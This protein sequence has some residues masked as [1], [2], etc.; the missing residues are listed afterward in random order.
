M[1][2]EQTKFAKTYKNIIRYKQI[3][4]VLI[5]H[6]FYDFVE[7]SKLLQHLHPKDKQGIPTP[8]EA[9]TT[10]GTKTH[11][12]RVR[13]VLE[14]LGPTFIKLGQFASNRPDLIP[15]KL[16]V[17]LHKLLDHVPPFS[18]EEAA[19]LI[20]TEL[21][22]EIENV[23]DQ[24]AASPVA[25]ASIAQVHIGVLKNG[26]KVAVKIQRPGIKKVILSDLEVMFHI[27][28]LIKK[29]V[30]AAQVIDP[31]AIVE[32]FKEGILAEIDFKNESLNLE[33]FKNLFSENPN[34]IVPDIYKEYSTERLMIMEYIEGHNLSNLSP[35][36]PPE[37]VVYSR[38]TKNC[39][40]IV[41]QQIFEYGYFHADPHAGNIIICENNKIC[42]VDFGLMG[43][44]PPKH[45][46]YLCQMIYGLV[47]NN[48]EQIVRAILKISLNKEVENKNVLENEVFKIIDSYVHLPLKDINISHFLRDIISTIVKNKISLPSNMYVLMK[49]M[50]SLEGTARKFNPDFNMLSH[51]EPFV[52]R[53]MYEDTSPGKLMKELYTSSFAYIR[54]IRDLP[55][56][57]QDILDLIK[58]KTLKM[59]FEHKG[60]E[61][62]L[63]KHDQIVNRL[64][65]AV[66]TASMLIGSAILLKAHIPPKIG[67]ISLFG[68]GTFLF[69]LFMGCI[70]LISILKHGKM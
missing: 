13:L 3:I 15:D 34:L 18:D 1:L 7:N 60:L 44:L 62:M 6:G 37:G 63:E 5:K 57:I 51:I 29:H 30:S 53:M 40:Q 11:W 61:P 28:A 33:K 66:V 27:A 41:L 56:E 35:D 52:K 55:V 46:S 54:L 31:I 14:E 50:V 48:T 65:F 4:A 26:K 20:E 32:E 47:D 64:S 69:S 43:I 22:D 12:E 39:A 17:E 21:G 59:Q 9:V 38:V 10:P 2:L 19:N 45:K 23:F 24:F 36:S 16:C 42:L 68:A 8:N 49:S 70:L 67:S 58:N 25:S